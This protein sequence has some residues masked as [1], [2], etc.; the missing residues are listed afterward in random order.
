MSQHGSN[1]AGNAIFIHC[2]CCYWKRV[3]VCVL[4]LLTLDFKSIHIN[5]LFDLSSKQN[6]FAVDT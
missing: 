6:S 4:L 3:G 2:D 5:I 1:F